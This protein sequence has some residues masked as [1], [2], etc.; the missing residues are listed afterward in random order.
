MKER[1]E[2]YHRKKDEFPQKPMQQRKKK[3]E[4]LT[5]NEINKG[6]ATNKICTKQEKIRKKMK[7]KKL[8]KKK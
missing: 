4:T 7:E 1:I 5:K 8:L 3:K 6:K 2:N